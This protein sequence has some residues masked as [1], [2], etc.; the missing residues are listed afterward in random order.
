MY[1]VTF[2][3]FALRKMAIIHAASFVSARDTDVKFIQS[4]GGLASRLSIATCQKSR[5]TLIFRRSPPIASTALW[6]WFTDDCGNSS[7]DSKFILLNAIKARPPGAFLRFQRQPIINVIFSLN[8]KKVAYYVVSR[9]RTVI[10][11]KN[12]SCTTG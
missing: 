1:T 8:A 9:S 3:S 4:A 11:C 7:S 6:S 12:Q 10:F 5:I 2:C